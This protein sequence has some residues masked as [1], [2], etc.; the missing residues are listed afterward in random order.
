MQPTFFRQLPAMASNQQGTAGQLKRMHC[1]SKQALCR[2]QAIQVESSRDHTQTIKTKITIQSRKEFH[3]HRGSSAGSPT[4]C[5]TLAG[6][7]FVKPRNRCKRSI[8]HHGAMVPE[9]PPLAP[10][11]QKPRTGTRGVQFDAKTIGFNGECDKD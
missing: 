4:H 7:G 2:Q 6:E 8:E 10:R 3:K 9:A 11:N 1:R 5:T